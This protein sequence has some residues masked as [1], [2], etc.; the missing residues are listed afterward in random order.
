MTPACA[1]EA[2][3]GS[4]GGRLTRLDGLLLNMAIMALMSVIAHKLQMA[5]MALS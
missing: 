1:G 2:L 4:P 5:I 3:S